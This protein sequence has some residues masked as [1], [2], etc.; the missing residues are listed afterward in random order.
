MELKLRKSMTCH[1][2][3]RGPWC[4]RAA[5][6]MGLS[7]FL[8]MVY[9]FGFMNLKDVPGF[10]IAFSVILSLIISVAFILVLKLPRL[11]HPIVAASLAVAYGVDYFFVERM[12]FGGVV[13]AILVLALTGMILAAVLGYVPQRKWLLWAAMGVLCARVLFVDLIGYVLPLSDLKLI[14]YIPKASNL[15]GVAA[16]CCLCA[17]LKLRKAET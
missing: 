15:F 16:V 8:R 14:A 13:T 3:N 17:S 6:W 7:F 2:D 12:N 1:L 10:E 4:E 5:A 9:Y 11:R